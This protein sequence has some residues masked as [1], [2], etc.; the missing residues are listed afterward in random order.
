MLATIK[1]GIVLYC[2]V[3]AYAPE[4]NR[5]G[6]IELKN[7]ETTTLFAEAGKM[8]VS[9][10]FVGNSNVG[11]LSDSGINMYQMEDVADL[12]ARCTEKKNGK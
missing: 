12:K 6:K 1:V 4:F 11:F 3:F 5:A 8:L 7:I 2:S 9:Y 10:R